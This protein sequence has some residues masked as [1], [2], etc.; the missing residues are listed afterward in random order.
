MGKINSFITRLTWYFYPIKIS[1]TEEA[2]IQVGN[3]YSFCMVPEKLVHPNS[4]IYSFGAGED[5]HSDIEMIRKY[6]CEII[7]FDPTPKSFEHFKNLRDKTLAGKEYCTDLGH[8][9]D[10]TIKEIEKIHFQKLALWREDSSIKFFSPLNSA[11]VSHSITNIQNSNQYITVAGKKLSTIMKEL[12]HQHIDYLK[13]DI[14]GAE[15]EVV[16]N[17]IEEGIDINAIYIEYHYANSENP[18]K[19]VQKIHHSLQR[20]ISSGFQIIH[21]DKNRYYTL[22]KKN[23]QN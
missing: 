4:V 9:Y 21:N 23:R 11:H 1:K 22:V 17:I 14:E 8:P 10:V 15:F 13:L 5:I 19:N 20:L 2:A 3:S 18:L 7:I 12:N 6:G 16:E